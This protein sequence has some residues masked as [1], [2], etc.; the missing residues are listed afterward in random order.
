[1]AS[2]AD[3]TNSNG[4]IRYGNETYN[5]TSPFAVDAQKANAAYNINEINSV[6]TALAV[7]GVIGIACLVGFVIFRTFMKQYQLR[8]HSPSITIKPPPF[9]ATGLGRFL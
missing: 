3:E 7:N 4:G 2:A 1:M 8:L 6:I 9:P 5:S